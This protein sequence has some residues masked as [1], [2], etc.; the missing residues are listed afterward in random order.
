MRSV[1]WILASYGQGGTSINSEFK[2]ENRKRGTGA[3]ETIPMEI[4]DADNSVS[5][6]MIDMKADEEVLGKFRQVMLSLPDMD[7]S[8][9][10]N[11]GIRWIIERFTK[12]L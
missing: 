3:I 7:A 12:F 4:Y 9:D 5:N 11:E 10:G 2:V 1:V 8:T 6:Q